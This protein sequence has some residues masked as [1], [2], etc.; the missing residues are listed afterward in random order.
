MAGFFRRNRRFQRSGFVRWARRCVLVPVLALAVLAAATRSA[1]TGRY[2]CANGAL[3]YQNFD[4]KD[5]SGASLRISAG[6]ATAAGGHTGK[7]LRLPGREFAQL[8]APPGLTAAAGTVSFRVR[9]LW[10]KGDRA[11]RAFLSLRWGDGRDSYL[12]VSSGWWEPTGSG[13]LYFILSNQEIMHC[14]LPYEFETD[15]WTHITVTWQGGR[16]GYCRLFLDGE[17]AAEH[18]A[19]FSGRYGA[20][21]PLFLGS[22]MGSTVP[23]SRESGF[24]LDDLIVLD[25]P[26]AETEV[27]RFYEASE[28]LQDEGRRKKRRWL[29]SLL[30][31]TKDLPLPRNGRGEFLER[32]VLFDEDIRW[33]LSRDATDAIIS[34]MSRAGFNVYVPCV[35]HGRG[36]HYPSPLAHQDRRVAARIA[37]GDDPL[38]Y[39]LA[40]AHGAGIEVHPWFTVARREDD[41]YAAFHSPGVPADAFDVHNPE[42]RAFIV[43]LMTDLVERYPV[44][45]VNLDYIRTMGDCL[46]ASCRSAYRRRFGRELAQDLKVRRDT[47]KRVESLEKWHGEAVTGIVR[48]FSLRAKRLRPGLVVSV[49]AHPLNPDLLAQGQDSIAWERDGWVDVVF[50]MDYR[51]KIDVDTL[52]RARNSLRNPAALTP[53]VST[54]DTRSSGLAPRYEQGRISGAMGDRVVVARE[55]SLLTDLIR[56]SRRLWPGSGVA[57][58]HEKRLTDEQVEALGTGVFAERALPRWRTAGGL[59]EKER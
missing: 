53:L 16:D 17:K 49:A 59:G 42:F 33:A 43:G 54:Y 48:E 50:A 34:R 29:D 44:D 36:T 11:S 40:K 35:W 4:G 2:H 39:L 55:P 13:K 15:S 22:D 45:G 23:R 58:Y 7:A 31:G 38:R 28:P 41:R 57:F 20:K 10:K 9:P 18:R 27:V 26:L 5:G 21:G 30:A 3:L 19:P 51:E 12:A 25:R 37:A 8:N 46:C 56:V 32:R 52:S 6:A 47:G 14:S 1:H 24:L